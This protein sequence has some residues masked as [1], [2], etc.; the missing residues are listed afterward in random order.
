[1]SGRKLDMK[2]PAFWLALALLGVG[3]VGGLAGQ[4]L[5]QTQEWVRVGLSWPGDRQH[6]RHE[7]DRSEPLIWME[8]SRPSLELC[9]GRTRGTKGQMEGQIGAVC[10]TT[11]ESPVLGGH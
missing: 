10:V 11:G 9:T 1:M 5:G 4:R 2:G 6:H 8:K 3:R 7:G